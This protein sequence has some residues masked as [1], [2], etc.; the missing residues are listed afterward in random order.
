ME[1]KTRIIVRRRIRR[2]PASNQKR[3][4]Q[5][6]TV[7]QRKTIL[8]VDDD[9]ELRRLVSGTLTKEG[10]DVI[11]LPNGPDAALQLTQV[12]F[13]AVIIELRMSDMAGAD[14]IH[15]MNRMCPETKVIVLTTMADQ[16]SRF[17]SMS[18]PDGVFAYLKKPCHLEDLKNTL[19]R[20]FTEQQTSSGTLVE[21][22]KETI[23]PVKA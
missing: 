23:P 9:Q 2:V 6:R 11:D 5:T 19:R 22:G 18:K 20:A 14:L 4:L 21:P 3:Q 17:Q 13:H 12:K 10:Y 1:R 7:Y 16:G 8:I 15:V